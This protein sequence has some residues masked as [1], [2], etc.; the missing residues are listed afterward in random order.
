M[1]IMML[2]KEE[3]V[4]IVIDE[5][6][7][8]NIENSEKY[9][10]EF[11]NNKLS[12]KLEEEEIKIFVEYNKFFIENENFKKSLR[13]ELIELPKILEEEKEI[14]KFVL[15]KIINLY[16]NVVENSVEI[17]A[18]LEEK[19]KKIFNDRPELEEKLNK[20]Y[21]EEKNLKYL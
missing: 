15:D 13:E 5:Y 2:T 11:L 16:K 9:L 12:V 6:I 3:K 1:V 14:K 20:I 8:K 18:E 7:K 21:Y 17:P 10:G 19:F 4:R